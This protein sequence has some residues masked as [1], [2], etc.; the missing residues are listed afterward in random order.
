MTAPSLVARQLRAIGKAFLAWQRTR[1]QRRALAWDSPRVRLA[2]SL[3]LSAIVAAGVG[4]GFYLAPRAGHIGVQT[5]LTT[6]D[7]PTPNLD[8]LRTQVEASQTLRTS[9][10]FATNHETVASLL[11]RLSITDPLLLGALKSPSLATPFSL[12][13]PGQLVSA[14]TYP[15]GRVKTLSILV[16]KRQGDAK[17]YTLTREGDAFT[18]AW[19]PAPLRKE[20]V[21]AQVQVKTSSERAIRA[22][23]L[24]K[25]IAHEL[26]WCWAPNANPLPKLK[27][28]AD[29]QVIYSKAYDGDTFIRNAHLEAVRLTTP[30]KTG[31]VTT[32]D[33]YR[34]ED[35]DH[36]PA[37]YTADGKAVSQTF[38]KVPLAITDI[39]SDFEILRRHPVTGVLRPHQGTDYR[40]PQGT[41]I[42][43]AADGVITRRQYNPGGYGNYIILD[44]GNGVETLYAHMRHFAKGMRVGLHVK[45]GD[46]IGMVGRTG[47]AT[48][49]HLHY[50]IHMNEVP[51][52]PRTIRLPESAQLTGFALAHF[53]RTMAPLRDLLDEGEHDATPPTSKES[54]HVLKN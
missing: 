46:V 45:Q 28:G 2:A 34:Y 11:A 43:A 40:A 47:I 1:T 16:G 5:R 10:L 49:P 22:L 8:A 21:R 17:R 25:T 38:I 27:P 52:N 23:H 24:P 35:A 42:H 37:Y 6:V 7:L 18:G 30:T 32:T 13:A 3:T 9:S 41:H 15:D 14:T 44:H 26:D 39:S 36:P 20:M 50:E 4:L 19:A 29:I 51:V 53:K 48:G 33:I 54:N 31:G 12:V